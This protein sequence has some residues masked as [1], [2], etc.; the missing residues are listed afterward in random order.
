MI[1]SPFCNCALPI[2]SHNR[3]LCNIRAVQRYCGQKPESDVDAGLSDRDVAAHSDPQDV[4]DLVLAHYLA[5]AL[6]LGRAAELLF[7]RER[8]ESSLEVVKTGGLLGIK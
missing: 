3:Y 6:S 2:V 8:P 5:G 4:F 7:I 1:S